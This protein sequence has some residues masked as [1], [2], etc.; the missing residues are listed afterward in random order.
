MLPLID[1]CNHSFEPN[2]EARPCGMR[3]R[4]CSCVRAFALTHHASV[5][6]VRPGVG[7]A[8]LLRAL[9]PVAPGTPLLLS[10]GKLSNDYLLMDYGAALPTQNAVR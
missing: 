6:Q 5:S 1:I 3:L 7:G 8:V 4:F 9:A 10:Y 2:V